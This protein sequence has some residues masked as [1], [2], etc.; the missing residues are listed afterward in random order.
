MV[1][2]RSLTIDSLCLELILT[3]GLILKRL[4]STILSSFPQITISH[5]AM[6]PCNRFQEVNDS[7]LKAWELLAE[8]KET[9]NPSKHHTSDNADSKPPVVLEIVQ[10][11]MVEQ[12][13]ELFIIIDRLD[14]CISDD[15]DFGVRKELL[16]RL[17][18]I[19]QR[20]R[21]TR[22]V[23]TSTV[24]AERVGTLRGDENWIRN[25]WI[26]TATAVSM[27]DP[28]VYDEW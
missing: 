16:P 21:N 19:P 20:W 8:R 28:G 13:K 9:L 7:E 10:D 6:L 17:Q 3:R 12:Q 15:E 4:I 5:V 23:V 27:D 1:F 26:D 24:M 14:M 18:D 22:V 2:K 25:V 11:V